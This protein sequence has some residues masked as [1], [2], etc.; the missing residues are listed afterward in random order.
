MLGIKSPQIAQGVTLP[1]WLVAGIGGLLMGVIL[2][3]AVI[4]STETGSKTLAA[5]AAKRITEAG[6]R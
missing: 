5:Y 2:G 1:I 6:A 4:S 3:P